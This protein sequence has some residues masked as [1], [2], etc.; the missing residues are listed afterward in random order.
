MAR[1][2]IK[3][4]IHAITATHAPELI[5]LKNVLR[6]A[7]SQGK[8]VQGVMN[9]NHDGTTFTDIEV[10]FGL[11]TGTGQTVFDLVNGAVGSM[12]GLFQVSDAKNL[13]ERVG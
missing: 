11:P 13:T 9:H 3:I 4:D 8:K 6:E 7:Y 10:L 12:E 1:D 2:F 5:R